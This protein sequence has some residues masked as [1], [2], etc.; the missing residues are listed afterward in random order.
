MT[1]PTLN[2]RGVLV[3]LSGP[4][5]L[6]NNVIYDSG[7]SGIELWFGA[8]NY[9]IA[10]NVILRNE[11]N[12]IIIAQGSGEDTSRFRDNRGLIMRN[13]IILDSQSAGGDG[14]IVVGD[15]PHTF[16]AYNNTIVSNEGNGIFVEEGVKGC[17]IRNNIVASNGKIGLKNGIDDAM[18]RA[19]NTFFDTEVCSSGVDQDT[20]HAVIRRVFFSVNNDRFSNSDTGTSR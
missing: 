18:S 5:E 10:H 17:D 12:G 7:D 14:I 9:T 19:Y 20:F 1:W 4:G 16:V 6:V 8:R 15:Q 3:F 13:N 11:E 2:A